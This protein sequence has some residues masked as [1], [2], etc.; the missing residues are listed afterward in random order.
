[1]VIL[2][3]Y[4]LNNHENRAAYEAVENMVKKHAISCIKPLYSQWLIQTEEPIS[5]WAARMK[6]VTDKDDTW[7]I[8]RLTTSYRGY[9]PQSVINWLSGK[10]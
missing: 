10:V 2:V 6:Q 3:S 8:D 5:T 4:D 7:L 9:L 1:M